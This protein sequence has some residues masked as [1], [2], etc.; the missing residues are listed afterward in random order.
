MSFTFLLR[1][2]RALLCGTCRL[3]QGHG[4]LRS[5]KSE[6]LALCFAGGVVEAPR[7]RGDAE[8]TGVKF[9]RQVPFRCVGETRRC[10]FACEKILEDDRGIRW[11]N[12]V[13]LLA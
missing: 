2:R 7:A 6:A 12:E 1:L 4:Q 5:H 8:R 10:V 3:G 11:L 9:N 13:V